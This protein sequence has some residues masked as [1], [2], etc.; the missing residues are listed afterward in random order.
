[1]FTQHVAHGLITR[2]T[3]RK[4]STM[5]ATY[6][7]TVGS[8]PS[9]LSMRRAPQRGQVSLKP[10]REWP[11]VALPPPRVDDSTCELLRTLCMHAGS[12][13]L[14]QVPVP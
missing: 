6:S 5:R 1:M 10:S 3:S 4:T 14:S 2:R 13:P 11:T 12:L 7:P 8:M 9:C